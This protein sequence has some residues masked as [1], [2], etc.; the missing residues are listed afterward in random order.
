VTLRVVENTFDG[1]LRALDTDLRPVGVEL[2]GN[3]GRETGVA[4]LA[5]LE[6]LGDDIAAHRVVD[7]GV[8]RLRVRSSGILGL[9]QTRE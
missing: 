5:H 6:M 7:V 8:G 3:D 1:A 2:L 4:A 9:I